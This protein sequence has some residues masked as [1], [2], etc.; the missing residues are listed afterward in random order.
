M[1]IGAWGKSLQ[2]PYANEAKFWPN[3]VWTLVSDHLGSTLW[4]VAYEKFDLYFNIVVPSCEKWKANSLWLPQIY[5]INVFNW[6]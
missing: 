6:K 1:G 2:L 3:M 4:A 5:L